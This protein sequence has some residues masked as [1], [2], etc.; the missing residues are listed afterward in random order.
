MQGDMLTWQ[1]DR[2][3]AEVYLYDAEGRYLGA[4]DGNQGSFNMQGYAPGVYMVALRCTDG[5][6]AIRKVLKN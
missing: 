6:S 1:A 2:A 3:V 5:S 4:I